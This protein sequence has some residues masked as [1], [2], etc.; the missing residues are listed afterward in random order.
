MKIFAVKDSND[1]SDKIL[2]YLFYYEINKEFY[3]ELPLD[4]DM[5]EAPLLLST[6]VEKGIYSVDSFFSKLWVD[7]R[8]V[9][10]DRQNLG[11]IL[12]D[13]KL[14]EYDEYKLLLLGEGRCAQDEYYIT[15]ISYHML[16]EEIRYR[17]NQKLVDITPLSDFGMIAFFRNGLT[18]KCNL[19]PFIENNRLYR[20]I[21][22]D[23]SLFREVQMQTD[24][25][26]ITWG[27]Q[28]S[29][30]CYDL[31]KTGTL[32]PLS[33]S[34]FH[35]FIIYRTVGTSETCELLECTRQNV[36]DLVRRDKLSPIRC[37]A[38]NK[39]FLKSDIEKRLWD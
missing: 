31:F 13:N 8:I 24:G 7:Q 27:E 35:D 4:V 34:D 30:S 19:K 22:A 14:K 2:A 1:S 37:Y 26:G 21:L 17:F 16:P 29:I 11:H 20:H 9:P 18:K 25:Y 38:K 6:F 12:R 28:L 33:A 36:D 23:D 10:P 15:P 5:W 3:I 39:L 32:L